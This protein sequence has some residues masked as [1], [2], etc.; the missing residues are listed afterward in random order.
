M[1]CSLVFQHMQ[2]HQPIQVRKMVYG[3]I[4]EDS[5]VNIDRE[6]EP[7][8]RY[9]G[10]YN[11]L[12]QFKIFTADAAV[13]EELVEAWYRATTFHTADPSTLASSLSR[14]G[15]RR[16]LNPGDLIRQDLEPLD[17]IR[18][19]EVD[20]PI[21]LRH[22]TTSQDTLVLGRLG[23]LCQLNKRTIIRIALEVP[24]RDEYTCFA[25]FF[26]VFGCDYAQEVD[27]L[28]APLERLRSEGYM[29]IVRA[30]QGLEFVVEPEETNVKGWAKRCRAAIT[31]AERSCR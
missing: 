15:W 2:R 23:S 17:L 7:E 18:H 19:V 9:A 22:G 11:H 27:Y 13:R 5:H 3:Y 28:F 12:L 24:D 14:F 1:Y 10:S 20:I 31:E 21:E 30:D 4:F 16:D 29:V 26:L 6:G 8:C 25:E